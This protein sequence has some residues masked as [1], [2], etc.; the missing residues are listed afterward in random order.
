MS[1]FK[2]FDLDLKKVSFS[3]SNNERAWSLTGL[4]CK[5]IEMTLKGKCQSVSAATTGMTVGCCAGRANN[6]APRCV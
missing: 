1:N 5:P 2:D 3:N 4:C 6:V